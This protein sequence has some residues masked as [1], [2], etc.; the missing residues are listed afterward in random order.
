MA[1]KSKSILVA[2]KP[3]EFDVFKE[4]MDKGIIPSDIEQVKKLSFIG[5]TAAAF[6]QSLINGMKEIEVAEEQRKATLADG[7]RAAEFLLDLE[8]KI[9]EI[10][11]ATPTAK[12]GRPKTIPGGGIVSK[13]QP[14]AER[15][16]LKPHRMQRA[17]Q[18]AKN[19]D[20]VEEVKKRARE[21]EDLASR[22]AVHATIAIKKKDEK[23]QEERK[24]RKEAE[25]NNKTLQAADNLELVQYAR[26][27]EKILDYLPKNPP[28]VWN[29][30]QLKKTSGLVKIVRKRLLKARAAIDEL[31]KRLEDF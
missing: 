18:L 16:G 30:K 29:E 3:K 9:G 2:S 25:A 4:A 26:S 14:K 15:L 31:L 5:Q 23:L 24:K 8:V 10:A 28:K 27:V 6:Y 22:T 7:Q 21:N 11:L 12:D 1:A 17:Q 13:E 19:K 20:V